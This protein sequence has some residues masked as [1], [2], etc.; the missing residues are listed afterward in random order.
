M[1]TGAAATQ[2][3][4]VETCSIG[5][6]TDPDCLGPCEPGTSVTLEGIVWQETENGKEPGKFPKGTHAGTHFLRGTHTGT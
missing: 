1:A 3:A 4:S 2:D 6:V 5:V